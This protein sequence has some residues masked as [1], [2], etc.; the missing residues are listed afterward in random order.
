MSTLQALLVFAGIP[1]LI[2]VVL[3]LLVM[4]PSLARGGSRHRPGQ[5]WDGAPEWFGGP[6]VQADSDR[7][8][9]TAGTGPG[10]A[11]TGGASA[12]W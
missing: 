11:D 8:R 5:E 2:M 6:E 9:L 12:R 1:L 7:P 4:V 3:T 10:S